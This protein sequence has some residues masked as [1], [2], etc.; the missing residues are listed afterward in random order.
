[1]LG[2]GAPRYTVRMSVS[3]YS[4]RRAWESPL[5]HAVAENLATF[6][7]GRQLRGRPVP[8]F[9]VRD[10]RA[11]LDCGV[12]SHGFLRVHCEECGRDR[13]VPLN[14]RRRPPFPSRR[15]AVRRRGRARG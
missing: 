6:L 4:P 9:V 2:K 12:P 1:L 13:V 11:F 5:Y 7:A 10:F 3:A 15:T 14:R 8:L